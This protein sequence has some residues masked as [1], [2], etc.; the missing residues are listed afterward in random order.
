MKNTNRGFIALITSVIISAVLLLVATNLNLTGF[1]AS[2][3]L[4]DY[5]LKEI[6][7]NLAEACVDTAILKIINNPAYSPANE[8]INIEGND[9]VIESIT[10]NVIKT[11][12]NY[13]N[14]I[15]HLEIELNLS[16]MSIIR[17]EEK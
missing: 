4:L 14:Y 1:Y 13:K 12:A 7:F 17:F 9:C 11:K 5:E 6:S 3:N 15:T 16:D 2:S 8:T 10:G